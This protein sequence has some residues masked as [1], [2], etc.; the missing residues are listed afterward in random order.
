MHKTIILVYPLFLYGEK[1]CRSVKS[2]FLI[3]KNF[4]CFVF[5]ITVLRRC[6]DLDDENICQDYTM[7]FCWVKNIEDIFPV[8]MAGIC[9]QTATGSGPFWWVDLKG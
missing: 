5:R 9:R 1:S 3:V 6:K 2:Q 7:T 8:F 4:V